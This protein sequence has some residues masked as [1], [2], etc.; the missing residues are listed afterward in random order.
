MNVQVN[1]YLVFGEK[2]EI[3][4][5]KEELLPITKQLPLQ[6]NNGFLEF[7]L[8][9]TREDIG[10]V[11]T[12]KYRVP[13]EDYTQFF[14][15]VNEDRELLLLLFDEHGLSGKRRLSNFVVDIL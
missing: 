15:H 13:V 7:V 11:N 3:I 2:E 4:C 6:P 10:Y 12:R 9:F 8:K 1:I 5:D 14:L